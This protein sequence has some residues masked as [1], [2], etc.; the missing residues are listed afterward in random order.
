M[1]FYSIVLLF[2]ILLKMILTFQAH[3]GFVLYHLATAQYL[4]GQII[5]Y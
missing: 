4:I 5:R 2:Q 3:G 1:M